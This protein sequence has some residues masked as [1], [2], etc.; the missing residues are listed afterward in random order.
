MDGTIVINSPQ[1]RGTASRKGLECPVVHVLVVDDDDDIRLSVRAMLEQLPSD[2][3]Y[4]VMEAADGQVAL[5][6]LRARTDPTVVLFDLVMQGM[7][8]FE[9]IQQALTHPAIAARCAFI[10]FPATP[11]RVTPDLAHLFAARGIPVVAKP[12][13]IDHLLNVIAQAA[14]EVTTIGSR[15]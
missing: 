8:G 6:I 14:D 11:A 9:L 7:D 5:D 10:C 15:R 13:D 2:R 4:Q 1:L 3:A 12:F